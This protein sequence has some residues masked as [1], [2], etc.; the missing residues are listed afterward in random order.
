[1]LKPLLNLYN[2]IAEAEKLFTDKGLNGKFYMDVYRGQVE[3]PEAF[4]YYSLPA[5]FVDYSMQGQ[6]KKQPRLITLNLH[7]V[8][9][10][11]PSASNIS[12]EMTKGLDVFMYNLLIQKLLEGKTIGNTSA[13][14]F[15]SEIPV[16][17]DVVNYHTQSWQ[18]EAYLDALMEDM[19]ITMGEF[20]RLSIFGH[21]KE[22][23]SK[24]K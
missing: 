12:E 1:M 8:T 22:I 21:L 13:L 5:I 7:I 17:A 3:E 23:H 6:G 20:E 10:A 18:F 15:L 24:I 9:D 16:T 14:V 19:E 11:T 4:E 2:R